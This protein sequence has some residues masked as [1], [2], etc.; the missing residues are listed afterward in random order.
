MSKISKNLDVILSLDKE[1]FKVDGKNFHQTKTKKTQIIIA[2]SLRKE[3]NQILHLQT[4]DFGA[5]KRWSTYTI[6][7]EGKIYQH[8][9]P[10]YYSDYMGIK[11]IDKKSISIV[12]ENMG[13]LIYD[14]NKESFINWINEECDEKLVYEKLWKNFRYWES[15]SNVQYDSLSW[16][17]MYLCKEYGINLDALGFNVFHEE[18]TNYQGIVTRSNYDSDYSDLNPSFDFQKFLKMMNISVE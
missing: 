1:T 12:L 11:E 4:K 2:G 7:R 8:Y 5:S 10:Q 3:S 17:C 18:T 9:D 16:L 15:Y 14:T 6:S 13:M